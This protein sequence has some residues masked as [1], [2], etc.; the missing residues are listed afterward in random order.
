VLSLS[1]DPADEMRRVFSG[2]HEAVLR[3]MTKIREGLDK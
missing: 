1:E 3:N 2:A